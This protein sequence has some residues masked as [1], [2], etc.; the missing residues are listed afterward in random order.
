MA[1]IYI[2]NGHNETM[3]L[4]GT[5]ASWLA[6]Q[7]L[8]VLNAARQAGE[9]AASWAVRQ[10]LY[11]MMLRP[12]YVPL[13]PATGMLKQKHP[14]SNYSDMRF[15]QDDIPVNNLI[16]KSK[17]NEFIEFVNAKIKV[18]KQNTIV[19]TVLVNR[20][21]TIKEYINAKDYV[22]D[23]SGD[24]MVSENRYPTFQIASV[25]RFLS[26]P[27]A[28]DVV[29]TYLDTF[30]ISK[31]VFEKGDFDQQ[32]Q[33]HFNVLPFKFIFKSDNDSENA[34]GLIIDN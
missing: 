30:G 13:N 10:K 18:T 12:A 11:K 23:V 22:V 3:R 7:S 17:N 29:N 34:Y 15:L 8:N 2:L 1:G 21:G 25:S 20:I 31:M 32:K 24:I 4:G 6:A 26:E 33:T 19:E 5:E 27:E 9:T 28:F 14:D 16:L